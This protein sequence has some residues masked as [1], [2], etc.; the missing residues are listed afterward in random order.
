MDGE[1]PQFQISEKFDFDGDGKPQQVLVDPFCIKPGSLPEWVQ[2]G[3]LDVHHIPKMG[4]AWGNMGHHVPVS[5][6]MGFF[7]V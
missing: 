5:V 6:F 4:Q 3:G 1:L 7:S 2:R